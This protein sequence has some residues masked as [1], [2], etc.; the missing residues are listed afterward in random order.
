MKN[1]YIAVAISCAMSATTMIPPL[2][3]AEESPAD[4][5]GVQPGV[6]VDSQ[7]K[8]PVD[9]GGE[10]A[11]QPGVPV[12]D[13]E[14]PLVL[15]TQPG[16]AP[17]AAPAEESPADLAQPATV[18]A[19][20]PEQEPVVSDAA[21]V[22]VVAEES[23]VPPTEVVDP[24]P[25]DVGQGWVGEPQNPSPVPAAP[26]EVYATV[27]VPEQPIVEA[28]LVDPIVVQEQPALVV[29]DVDP[30]PVPEQS[31]VVET[32]AA[33]E[34]AAPPVVTTDSQAEA[35][36]DPWPVDPYVVAP[37]PEQEP[38]VSDAA[39]VPV[40]AEESVVPPTEVVDPQPVDVGQG[41]VGEP[42]N[43]SPVPA[44]PAEVYATVPVPEQPIVEAA[45]VDPIVVQEQPA[46][47]VNDVD[48]SP[49]PEQSEVVETPAATEPAAPPVVMDLERAAE[50]LSDAVL[51]QVSAAA[52]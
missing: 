46:L 42:Q 24:Q 12:A 35:A 50:Q 3:M 30:S 21:L 32:P 40:V 7:P 33:T 11:T 18:V 39:L 47:V 23:V 51:V 43:P 52:E 38:V 9:S 5:A 16:I 1:R 45:L 2:A 14:A 49:V 28:A 48:P 41:W 27:P 19:P 20:L 15:A 22:P 10:G 25:V 34:P 17:S 13:D 6:M 8:G 37:L 36:Y 4:S 31:E 29:N 44:A 26:A